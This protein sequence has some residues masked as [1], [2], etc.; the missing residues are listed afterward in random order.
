M[1]EEFV[2]SLDVVKLE[3]MRHQRPGVDPAGRDHFN[4]PAHALFTT[5]AKGAD[6]LVVPEPCG[7]CVQWDPQIA[8]IDPERRQRAAR[9]QHAQRGFERVLG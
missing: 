3:T 4:Q 5:W 1:R 6:D 7:K 2:G 9:S 8:R